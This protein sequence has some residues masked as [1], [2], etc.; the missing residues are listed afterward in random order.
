MASFQRPQVATLC[1]RLAESPQHLIALFGPRQT[2]KTTIVRQALG[3]SN[4]QYR[5][6]AA[7]EPDSDPTEFRVPS[8]AT[9]A[10]FP[11]QEHDAEWL[12]RQWEEARHAAKQLGKFVLV[13]DEIQKVPQ[14]SETVKGLW[15]AD[16]ARGCPLHVVI[17]GSAPL[18][19]QSGLKESLTGR[20]ERIPV[21]HWSFDEMS[22]AFNF[23]LPHYLYFGGYP[24]AASLVWDPDR[25]RDYILNSLID[26]NIE[27]DLLA[28]TRVD[29]PALL[30]RL[31]EL[32]AD[33]SGQIRTYEK[34]QKELFASNDTLKHYLDL[35][36]KA[37]L[38]T[39]V[40]KYVGKNRRS[41]S[42]PKLNVLNTALMTAGSRYSFAKARAD[43]SFWGRIVESAVGAHLFNTAASEASDI[44]LH[45]W[46]DK[47]NSHK[48]DQ[49]VDFVL[50]RGDQIV[51]I[52]VKSGTQARI[53]KGM[54]EF[55]RRFNPASSLLV[56][57]GG[58]PLKEFLV[59][60]AHYWFEQV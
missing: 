12:V 55:K 11:R 26:P 20:F 30:K 42:S 19:V 3:Q 6:R 60:P 43:R 33:Y 48:V 4:L 29:K 10:T 5:Y 52:E 49:E 24:G 21:P 40:Q 8:D 22:K 17:L 59:V 18:S 51:A 27:Q 37:G 41:P 53:P 23:A 56:G 15:D 34:M 2:G 44:R 58:I 31:F 1:R 28:M 16:R 57:E 36:E 47:N 50:Q 9:E 14:W 46:R 13:L 38:L 32:G 25:W 45:Y 54:D 7:D 39:S 35:L